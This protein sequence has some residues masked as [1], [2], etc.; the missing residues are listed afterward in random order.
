MMNNV[1][2]KVVMISASTGK[3]TEFPSIKDA[4]K[5][6]G[7]HEPCICRCCN[8]KQG[9]TGGFA[10]SYVHVPIENPYSGFLN[11]KQTAEKCGISERVLKD[12]AKKLVIPQVS[13]GGK[14]KYFRESDIS[15]AISKDLFW[16][17]RKR[18]KSILIDD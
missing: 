9:M 6:T 11:L 15:A 14:R 12:K 17:R 3:R 18:Q 10:F 4:S 1:K 8:G 5:K 2:R 13:R 16:D 7:L